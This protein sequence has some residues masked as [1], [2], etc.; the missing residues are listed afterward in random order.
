MSIVKLNNRS[1]KDITAFGSISNLGNF[2][3]ISSTTASNATHLTITSGLSSTYKEYI[4]YFIN[5]HPET[6]DVALKGNFTTDG[7]NFNVT[8]NSAFFGAVQDAGDTYSGISYS[9]GR[10]VALGTGDITLSQS[11]GNDNDDCTCGFLHLFN[12]ASTTFAKAFK[13]RMTTRWEVPSEEACADDFGAGFLVTTSAVTGFRCN[14]SSG[15]LSG[16]VLLFGLD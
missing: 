5:M 15:N 7:T 9:T 11:V 10:D 14:M 13:S 4:F 12:P 1:V 16:T 8:K 2:N 3:F 6:N